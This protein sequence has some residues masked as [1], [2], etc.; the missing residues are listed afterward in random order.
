MMCSIGLNPSRATEIVDDNTIRKERGFSLRLGYKQDGEMGATFGTSVGGYA[1]FRYMLTRPGLIKPNL[2][3]LRS[4]DPRGLLA[5]H[6]RNE[7][8][9]DEINRTAIL[10]AARKAEIV[11]CAWG[12]PYHPT[13]LQSLIEIEAERIVI[14]LR[15]AGI[16]LFAFAFTKS[17]G[18]RHPLYLPNDTKP[19]RWK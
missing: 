1:R 10:E 14:M 6:D 15:G 17:G 18:C 16:E 11:I 3:P 12:G 2:F 13:R 5:A 7:A 9:T 4:T 8:I 19:I